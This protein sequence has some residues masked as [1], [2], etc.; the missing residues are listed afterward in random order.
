MK[1]VIASSVGSTHYPAGHLLEEGVVDQLIGKLCTVI[2]ACGLKDS[3]E[4]SIKD[5]IKQ[6]VRERFSEDWG[7]MYVPGELNGVLVSLHAQMCN[8]GENNRNGDYEVTFTP[9]S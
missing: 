2:D 7:A 4:K 6:T 1:K 8:L 5:L 9:H 3:Q